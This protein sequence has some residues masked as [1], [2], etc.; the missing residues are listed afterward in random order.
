MV[1][2]KILLSS[3]LVMSSATASAVT[4][5]Q[6]LTSGYNHNEELK[7]IREDFLIEIEA[8]PRALAGFMPKLSVGVNSVDSRVD[9]RS[10]LRPRDTTSSNRTRLTQSLVLEQPIFDGWSSVAE[11]KAAQSGFRAARG[12]YYSKEQEAF[13]K[14]INAYLGCVEAKEK[15]DISKISVKSNKTQLEA[16]KEKFKLGEATETEV[17]SAREGLATAEANQ[18]LSYA[19][20]EFTKASF[21]RIFGVEAIGIKMSV[22]PDNLP[23]S[24]AILTE[25]AIAVNPYVDSAGHR[26]QSLKASE[27]AT[28]GRLLPRA[29][30]RVE[31]N[32]TYYAPQDALTN[33]FNNKSTTATLSVTVPILEK[34][35]LEYSDVRRAKYQTK[36]AAIAFDSA[37]KQIKASCKGRW[38]ELDAARVRINATDQAVKAA[39][40]AYD[41]MMQEEMLG[42]KT[43]VDVLRTEERLHKARKGRVEAN[44][45][46]L[47]TAYQIKSLVGELTAKSMKLKVDYFNPEAEFKKI[48]M[49]IIGF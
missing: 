36:K 2:R 18:A 13:L 44:K 17:A 7:I 31:N 46:M 35:G 25:R 6:A 14:E 3:I 43:I 38:A 4:M 33:D 37:I 9:K 49:K 11:L 48:K 8:F 22:V 5:E 45:A 23:S 28:K 16:M 19:N 24:L 29:S 42:S 15:Y 10:S 1:M 21:Y 39:E 30:F 47:L 26:T 40:V 27:C 12:D 41:G 20:Y 34:G 32:R